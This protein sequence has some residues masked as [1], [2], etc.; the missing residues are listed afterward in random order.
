MLFPVMTKNLNWEILAKALLIFR[1]WDE[2]KDENF[3][4]MRVH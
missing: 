3:S 1:R 2:L 4:I